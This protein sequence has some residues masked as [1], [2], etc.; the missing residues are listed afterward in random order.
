MLFVPPSL[1][2]LLLTRVVWASVQTPWSANFLK[3][4]TTNPPPHRRNILPT[5]RSMYASTDR[6]KPNIPEPLQRTSVATYR[7]NVSICPVKCCET[8][9]ERTAT[10]RNTSN[11]IL[12]S[13]NRPHGSA[14][15]ATIGCW[16]KEQLKV[17]GIDTSKFSAHS[18]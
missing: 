8:Y 6:E 4:S 9:L 11:S 1:L 7:Q 13:T 18:T 10:L 15:V 12:L 14:A 3:A 2:R 5:P 16:I 17:A